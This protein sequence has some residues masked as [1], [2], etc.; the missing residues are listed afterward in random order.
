MQVP[1]AATATATATAIPYL[2]HADI[3]DHSS[4]L[5]LPNIRD[6]LIRQEDTIIFALI[7]RAQFAHNEAVYQ[8]DGIPVPEFAACGRRYS[9]LE[10]FLRKTEA[11]HGSIRRY[12][13]PDEQAF[14][15]ED[16]PPIV[17]PGIE[18]KQVSHASYMVSTCIH[19]HADPVF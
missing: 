10:Y 16:L 6:S 2:Q 8:T 1:A 18:Y 15:P 7:E 3:Q 19:S 11:L 13:S 5:S 17:L 14:F 9:F 12:T 4:A